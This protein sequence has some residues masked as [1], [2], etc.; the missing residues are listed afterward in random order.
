MKVTA[1]CSTDPLATPLKVK[2]ADK[3]NRIRNG[4]VLDTRRDENGAVE[5][6]VHYDG[7]DRRLDEWVGSTR[8]KRKVDASSPDLDQ[9]F[10]FADRVRMN[11]GKTPEAKLKTRP[12]R[13]KRCPLTPSGPVNYEEVLHKVHEEVRILFVPFQSISSR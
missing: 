11:K 4:I 13:V 1:G 7:Q 2:V 3:L 12:E 9:L 6:Y 8:V 10:Q 5:Y